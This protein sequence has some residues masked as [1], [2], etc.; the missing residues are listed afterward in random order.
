M[1][2]PAEVVI[3]QAHNRDVAEQGRCADPGFN[4][5]WIDVGATANDEVGASVGQVQITVAIDMTEIAHAPV[6]IAV[7][8]QRRRADVG[9]L[10]GAIAEA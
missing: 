3:G 8:G 2:P 9:V 7:L 6:P 1:D 4:L 10:G 5:S